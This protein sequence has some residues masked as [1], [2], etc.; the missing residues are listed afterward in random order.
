MRPTPGDDHPGEARRAAVLGSPVA[1]SLSP[2]LHLAAY[3][4]LGLRGWTY[5]R[6]E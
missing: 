1:H 5:E 3:R 4:A 2:Q 6:I